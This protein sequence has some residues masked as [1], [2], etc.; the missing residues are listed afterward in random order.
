MDD[1]VPKGGCA[2]LTDFLNLPG[3]TVIP[4][5]SFELSDRYLIEVELT[6][7]CFVCPAC[8]RILAVSGTYRW[9]F[10]D[11]PRDGKCVYVSLAGAAKKMQELQCGSGSHRE[12]FP[13]STKRPEQLRQRDRIQKA[14]DKQ[15]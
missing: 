15:E 10:T 6:K 14:D 7:N 5:L 12:I 1:L 9:T 4:W 3:Y 13:A 2:M 11:T 8:G